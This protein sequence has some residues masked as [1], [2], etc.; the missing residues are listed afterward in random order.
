MVV[1]RESSLEEKADIEDYN[2]FA[3]I[4]V[5]KSAVPSIMLLFFSSS[6]LEFSTCNLAGIIG[7]SAKQ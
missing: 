1:R 4:W 6:W 7:R 5:E 2:R 3:N